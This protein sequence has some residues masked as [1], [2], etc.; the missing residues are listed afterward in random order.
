MT[1]STAFVVFMVPALGIFYAGLVRRKNVIS[2]FFQCMAV[3]AAVAIVW[4]LVGYSLVFGEAW[5]A[6]SVISPES[7]S[8]PASSRT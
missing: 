2:T 1:V 7:A 3:F 4:S 8:P 6:S 5:A